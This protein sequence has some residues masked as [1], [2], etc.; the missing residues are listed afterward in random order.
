MVVDNIIELEQDVL[1]AVQWKHAEDHCL[2]EMLERYSDA[3]WLRDYF[4][5]NK[6]NI[7]TGPNSG[8]YLEDM[9]ADTIDG[10]AEMVEKLTELGIDSLNSI[11]RSL[12]KSGYT[13]E[14][15]PKKMYGVS[16]CKWL[17]IYALKDDR[18]RFIITGYACKFSEK[19]Q[20]HTGTDLEL[21]K[22]QITDK[23]LTKIDLDSE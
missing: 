3:E 19:M 14:H 16:Y 11:F 22:L 12:G 10:V 2:N 5:S 21:K 9:V 13:Y 7:I 1:Y 20:E 18:G 6:T 4:K 23:F 17:R 15:I 8:K